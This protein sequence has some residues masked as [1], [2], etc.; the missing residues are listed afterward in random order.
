M[1]KIIH[2]DMDCFYAAIE[3]REDPS[4][5][6]KPLGIGGSA[7]RRGVL[8]TANYE[9]REFGVRSAMSTAYALRLC[10]QLELR[11]TRFALYR[12]V[13]A[14][15][16][17]IFQQYTD[18]IEPLSLDE[19]FLDVTDCNQCRG[20]ASLIAQEIRER[21]FVKEQLTASAGISVNKYLAKIASDWQKPNGQFLVAPGD[22]EEF[23]YKLP[24]K[25]I[26]GVGKA[27][28]QKLKR[29]GVEYCSDLQHFSKPELVEKF[30]K[31][32]LRLYD[33]CRGI[34]LR[35]VDNHRDRKSLSVEETFSQDLP[36]LTS[37]LEQLPTLFEKF[38]Q[39]LAKFQQSD[40]SKP[41]SKQFVKVKFHD[42]SQTTVEM[43]TVDLS[44]DLFKQL[45]ASGFKR[46][47]KP[48]RLLGVGVGFKE[49]DMFEQPFLF[50]NL[51]DENLVLPPF[52]G[53]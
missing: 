12:E 37:C 19:A 39:R 10:P 8:C 24:V 16:H 9:A 5:K 2:I 13:S 36:D 18:L 22:I 33:L 31:F 47:E 52:D 53:E 51:E 41:I 20:S 17:E 26:F 50:E 49:Q 42:F 3:M 6:G 32:G 28:Q 21:I 4:L 7:D 43:T 29:I 14:S 46:G 25:K 48:V 30:G 44:V 11:P 35:P 40:L 34:D 27:M 23:V 45:L 15:I 1:R 38:Q